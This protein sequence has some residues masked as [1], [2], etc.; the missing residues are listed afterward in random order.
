M[1]TEYTKNMTVLKPGVFGPSFQ[2]G[3]NDGGSYAGRSFLSGN[4]RVQDTDDRNVMKHGTDAN[5]MMA[6]DGVPQV[7]DGDEFSDVQTIGRTEKNPSV[8]MQE[9]QLQFDRKTGVIYK[10]TEQRTVTR[11]QATYDLNTSMQSS[12][13]NYDLDDNNNLQNVHGGRYDNEM[14]FDD[15]DTGRNA[16]M[17]HQMQLEAADNGMQPLEQMSIDEE[18]SQLDQSNAS[19]MMN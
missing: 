12:N 3:I 18:D 11:I 7:E 15:D 9:G 14:G 10:Q 4:P 1:Q 8:L 16:W 2:G 6:R 17:R 19:D 13:Q 5:M